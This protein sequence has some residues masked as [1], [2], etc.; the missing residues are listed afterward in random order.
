VFLRQPRHRSVRGSA[1]VF[2]TAFSLVNFFGALPKKVT[3][4]PGRN[5]GGLLPTQKQD[6]GRQAATPKKP[7]AVA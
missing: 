7:P 2:N 4:P 6:H 5:P 3:R 1:A